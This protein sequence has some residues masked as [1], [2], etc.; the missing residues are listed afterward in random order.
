[1]HELKR[2]HLSKRINS[3]SESDVIRNN[4]EPV[5]SRKFVNI[6]LFVGKTHHFL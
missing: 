4:S 1:M 3:H 5:N 6:R 2:K